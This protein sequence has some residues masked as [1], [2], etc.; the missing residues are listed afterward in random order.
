[1]QEAEGNGSLALQSLAYEMQ[2]EGMGWDIMSQTDEFTQTQKELKSQQTS[3]M[4][5]GNPSKNLK[6]SILNSHSRPLTVG[7][8]P[9]PTACC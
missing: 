8:R 9:P 1:M 3:M 5:Q 2:R 4:G 7:A 6:A